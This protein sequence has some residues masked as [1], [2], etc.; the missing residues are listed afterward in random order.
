MPKKK[1]TQTQEGPEAPKETVFS[2]VGA[3]QV[4]APNNQTTQTTVA[5]G[6]S[7]IPPDVVELI[8][9]TLKVLVAQR[10]TYGLAT[11][12]SSIVNAIYKALDNY[13]KRVPKRATRELIKNELA[14]M[15]YPVF[16]A[17]I[18][19]GGTLYE[20]ET[21]LLYRHLD[22]LVDMVRHARLNTMIRA[23]IVTEGIDPIFDKMVKKEAYV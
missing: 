9:N 1:K 15:G 10:K 5:Q 17:T 16:T 6:A 22:E 12:V 14:S 23:L 20:A 4:A 8:R 13:L 11:T 2:E 3:A 21:V 18:E 19:Y 7:Q